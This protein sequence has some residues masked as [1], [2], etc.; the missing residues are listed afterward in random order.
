MDTSDLSACPALHSQLSSGK[1]SHAYIVSGPEC[2]AKSALV[3]ALARALVCS[4]EGIKPCG[5]CSHCRK[6]ISGSHPDILRVEREAG[7]R[8]LAVDKIRAARSD[9]YI[10]PNEAARKVYIIEEAGTM[11]P[12]AQNALLK[13]LEEPPAYAVFILSAENPGALLPTVRSRCVEV[14]YLPGGAS[15]PV[16]DDG[17]AGRLVELLGS[18]DRLELLRFLGSLDSLSRDELAGFASSLRRCAVSGLKATESGAVGNR[19]LLLRLLSLCDRIEKY[20][21]AYVSSVHIIAMMMAE[22]L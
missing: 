12:A 17:K 6:A 21:D 8:E 2:E 16:V 20:A 1:F 13:V 15:L 19:D 22:L 10:V 11:N 18:G 7:K 4:G 9:A 14:P 5:V 3:A